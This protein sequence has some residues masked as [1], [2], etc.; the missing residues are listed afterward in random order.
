MWFRLVNSVALRLGVMGVYT[1]EKSASIG[2]MK[3]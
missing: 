1:G 2:V 3:L